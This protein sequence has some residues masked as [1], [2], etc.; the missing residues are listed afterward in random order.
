[1]RMPGVDRIVAMTVIAEIGIDVSM[2]PT[3]SHL[4]AWAG[5]CPGNHQSAGKNKPASARKGNR[6]L[7]T[8]LCN[9]A[10]SASRKN[11]SYY[12]DKYHKLK[13]R[14]GGGKAAL[15]IA[16]KLLV[17]I[18]HVL[19]GEPFRDLGQNYLNQRSPRRAAARHVKFLEKLGYSVKLEPL[20]QNHM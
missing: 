19:R 4:A 10:T 17:A 18:Y 20:P 5:V 12:K 14:I 15:A 1:M 7:K 3:A 9:A 11:G 13:A 16:H 2:F 8:T 6:H